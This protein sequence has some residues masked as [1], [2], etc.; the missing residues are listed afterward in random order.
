MTNIDIDQLSWHAEQQ[1]LRYGQKPYK[2]QF[3]D[4][5]F[6]DLDARGIEYEPH[7]Y[8]EAFD[9]I[10][11]ISDPYHNFEYDDPWYFPELIQPQLALFDHLDESQK[12][13]LL[14]EPRVFALESISDDE[15]RRRID[16][17]L[18]EPRP[19]NSFWA[20][21]DPN[22]LREY[23]CYR[24]QQLETSGNQRLRDLRGEHND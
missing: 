18:T 7:P 21:V 22:E 9:A 2:V 5:S 13:Y 20:N 15:L 6:A 8:E 4:A 12:L 24:K 23:Y 17:F 16:H 14:R 1:L 11:R 19:G 3:Q 10:T